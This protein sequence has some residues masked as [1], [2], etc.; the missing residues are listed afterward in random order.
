MLGTLFIKEL[1]NHLY[2]LRFQVSMIIAVLIFSIGTPGVVLSIREAQDQYEIYLK[3]Q[4]T[5]IE[6]QATAGLT[7]VAIAR[8]AFQFRPRANQVLSDCHESTLPNKI[9][10]SAF[11][12][13]GFEVA[14]GSINPLIKKSQPLTWSF[15][16]VMILSFLSL[17][18]AFDSISGEKENKTLALTLS[19]GVSRG[20]ILFA[21]FASTIC[22]LLLIE[23]LSIIIGLII[24]L[25]TGGSEINAALLADILGFLL[26]S[27]LF[28]SC[29]TAFGI[30]S[31]VIA[32]SSN[33]SLLISLSIWLLSAIIIPNSAVFWGTRLF[34]IES[35]HSVQQRINEEYEYLSDNAPPGSW[36]SSSDP[37]YPRNELRANLQM[38][39][40]INEKRHRDLYYA[41]MMEQFEKTRYFTLLSPVALFDYSIE[42]IMGG[43]YIRFRKNWEDLHI[44]QEQFLAWFKEKD[45]ADEGSP[46]WYN[47]H[48]TYS[49]SNEPVNVEEVPVYSESQ[50]GYGERI[51]FMLSYLVVFILYIGVIFSLSFI[52]FMRYDPR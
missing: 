44:H 5:Q 18:F 25:I 28:I 34:P 22:S 50:I 19:N 24:L 40:M 3:N 1:Q 37:F 8:N 48:E 27:L 26:L 14:H 4:A 41:E 2:S 6:Q 17:L 33:L 35:A 52:F 36:S 47:P 38:S 20:T 46:H 32:K 49:T 7:K 9:T 30:F 39:L 12:V 16:V 15:V 10:Y 23:I 21:K 11:N 45:A 29:F 42:A 31:S 51:R 43:G 13:F